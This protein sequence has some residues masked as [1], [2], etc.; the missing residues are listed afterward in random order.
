M[1]ICK[2]LSNSCSNPTK[3]KT[4]CLGLLPVGYMYIEGGYHSREGLI[5]GNTV[6][7]TYFRK[8]VCATEIPNF[9]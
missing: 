1:R 6:N 3:S 9:Y 7:K 2:Y 4:K 8:S 5:P